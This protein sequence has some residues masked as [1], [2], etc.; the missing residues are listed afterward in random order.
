[1]EM[2]KILQINAIP[3]N[4]ADS[5]RSAKEI[6]ILANCDGIYYEADFPYCGADF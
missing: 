5:E 2:D 3:F 4:Y 6:C 1:M